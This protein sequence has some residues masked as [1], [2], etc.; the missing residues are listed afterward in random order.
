MLKKM[1]GLSFISNR[2]RRKEGTFCASELAEIELTPPAPKGAVYV[3]LDH[4]LKI[5]FNFSIRLIIIR[6]LK[7]FQKTAKNKMPPPMPKVFKKP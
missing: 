2:Q 7:D 1:G 6:V 3:R 4:S 5:S